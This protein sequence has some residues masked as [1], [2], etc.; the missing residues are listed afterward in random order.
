MKVSP[1][2]LR[3][4]RKNGKLRGQKVGGKWYVTKKNLEAFL[5]GEAG[6]ELEGPQLKMWKV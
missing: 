5:S 2:T 4:Y 3:T 6:K 1:V